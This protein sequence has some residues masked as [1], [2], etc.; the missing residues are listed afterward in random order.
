LC[1]RDTLP[2]APVQ[3]PPGAVFD[4]RF[5]ERSRMTG[6]EETLQRTWME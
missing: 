3:A 2:V 1:G 4:R 5:V 6:V